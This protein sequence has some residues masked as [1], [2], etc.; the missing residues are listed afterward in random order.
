[1]GQ[2]FKVVGCDSFTPDFTQSSASVLWYK[3]GQTVIVISET[4]V[5]EDTATK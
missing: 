3:A 5:E 1:M 4:E 2:E